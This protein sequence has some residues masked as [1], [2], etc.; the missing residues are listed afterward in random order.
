ME[1]LKTEGR[2]KME[3]KIDVL[4]ED[5]IRTQIL[6]LSS[7]TPGSKEKST[8]VDDVVKLYRLKIDEYK[9]TAEWKE[10]REVRLAEKR[11]KKE[12]LEEKCKA[13]HSDEQYRTTQTVEQ[14][15]DRYF[16]V[17]IAVAELVLPLMFYAVWMQRGFRFE[18]TG[19]YTSTT[20]KGLFNRFKPT[21]K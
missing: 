20:F 3:E 2:L 16:R 10:K 21:R 4:L 1:L 13:R 19:T 17:G 14:I 5:E 18:E 7:L 12:E 11:I 15:K 6:S 9:N 8:A